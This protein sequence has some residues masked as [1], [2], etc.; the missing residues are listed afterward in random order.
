[1]ITDHSWMRPVLLALFDQ[2]DEQTCQGA[3]RSDSARQALLRSLN[4]EILL[5]GKLGQ[6]PDDQ[7]GENLL[8]GML[9]LRT[10]FDRDTAL[11]KLEVNLTMRQGGRG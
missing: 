3:L 7:Y 9:A 5:D 11:A 4:R 6:I 10:K 2:I 8:H 1:M